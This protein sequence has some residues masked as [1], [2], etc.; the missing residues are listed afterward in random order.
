MRIELTND[1]LLAKPFNYY[2]IEGPQMSFN[3]V[4]LTECKARSMGYSVRIELIN[5]SLLA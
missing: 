1:S 4:T 5:N 2:T 3:K